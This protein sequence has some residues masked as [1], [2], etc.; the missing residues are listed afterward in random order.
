MSDDGLA[1][2][3]SKIKIRRDDEVVL[4]EQQ[5]I[6]V[7]THLQPTKRDLVAEHAQAFAVPPQPM[8][9]PDQTHTTQKQVTLAQ[10]E[11]PVFS[12]PLRP[13]RVTEGMSVK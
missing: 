4:A 2:S 5:Y 13:V 1:A 11:P 10:G 3:E 6:S 12:K 8:I 7:H 9:Q